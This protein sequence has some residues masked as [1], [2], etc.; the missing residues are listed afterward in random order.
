MRKRGTQLAAVLATTLA[1][2]VTLAAAPG[3]P[4]ERLPT[5]RS[6]APRAEGL[7]ATSANR[8][9]NGLPAPPPVTAP[10]RRR[11]GTVSLFDHR[12]PLEAQGIGCAQARRLMRRRCR[13][14]LR[15][16]WTCNSFRE[17]APFVVWL[18]LAQVFGR[19]YYPVAALR[20]YPCSEAKVTPSLFAVEPRQGQFPSRRQLLADDLVRCHL[21]E[22]GDTVAEAEALLGPPDGEE[23]EAGHRHWRW[24]LGTERDSI[25]KIDPELLDLEITGGRVTAIEMVQGG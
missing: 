8:A 18:P 14:Y 3:A 16:T 7:P 22:P 21:L 5:A 20:R 24:I 6:V 12:F 10:G 17:D 4:A 2:L 19:R 11:C 23:A 25:F 1:A 13:D 15:G 9:A